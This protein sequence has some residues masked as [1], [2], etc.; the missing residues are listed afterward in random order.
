MAVEPMGGGLYEVDSASGNQYVVDLVDSICSCPDHAIRGE[1]CKHLRRVAIEVNRGDLPPP[2]K[3][4]GECAA[5]GRTRN[6]PESGPALCSDC[7]FEAGEPVRDRETGDLLVVAAVTDTPADEYVIEATDRTVAEH[8]T[9]DG[10]PTDDPVVEA[11]YPFS[12]DREAPLEEQRRYAFPHSRVARRDRQLG[13]D[14]WSRD[15]SAA[16]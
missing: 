12:G 9:N 5:C 10:Y 14:D 3:R 6:L 1:R 7:W 16:R 2:G 4:R 11:V 8:A 13:G 15:R